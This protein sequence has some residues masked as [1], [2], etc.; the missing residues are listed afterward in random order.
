MEVISHPAF[1]DLH[2]PGSHVHAESPERLGRLLESFSGFTYGGPATREQIERV[3][4]GEYVQSV[5]SLESDVWLDADTYAGPTTWEAALLAAGCS[6]RALEENGFALV[7][8][9]GHHA[10]A[11]RAMGFCIFD[12]VA[13][14]ARHAQELGHER[15]A[16]VDFDVHHGNGTEAIFRDDPSVLFVSVHQWPFYPG[17]GGPGTSDEHTLNVPLAAGSGDSEYARIFAETIEPA[18]NAFQPDVVLVS[19]GFDAHEEDPLAGMRVSV[20]GFRELARRCSALGPRTAAVL[21]GGYNLDTL[22]SLV[23]AALEG[24]SAG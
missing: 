14:A 11:D 15:V 19:A 4:A 13:I 8:P 5:E 12:N 17:T 22:P 23:E 1:A 18:V 7:R 21:E 24:F 3:H 10:L 20:E 9:P 6:I 16:I 2:S